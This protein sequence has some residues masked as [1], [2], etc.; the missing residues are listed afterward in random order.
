MTCNNNNML[1]CT[2]NKAIKQQSYVSILNRGRFMFIFNLL[3][4]ATAVLIT[5]FYKMY[6]NSKFDSKFKTS[7]VDS[8]YVEVNQQCNRVKLA[9]LSSLFA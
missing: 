2:F 1:H 9:K 6:L 3:Q 5:Q 7:A 4:V 8:W